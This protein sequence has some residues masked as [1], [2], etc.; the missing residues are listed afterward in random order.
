MKSRGLRNNNQGNIRKSNEKWQGETPSADPAFKQ[1]K[2]MDWGYRAM[3]KILDTYH[4][5]YKL[6][7]IR[8]LVSRWAPPNENDTEAY[9]NN[10]SEWSGVDP[11]IRIGT[12]TK[13]TM[14][15]IVCA[16]SRMENGT[17]AKVKDVEN[18][19]NLFMGIKG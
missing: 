9:V 8:Q 10:V 7:T 19:W 13:S 14:V 4:M 2:G 16:M 6:E 11:D 15:P 1:F 5:K 18:G 12:K 3:F 17:P